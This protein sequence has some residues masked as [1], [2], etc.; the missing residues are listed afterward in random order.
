MSIPITYSMHDIIFH[1]IFGHDYDA[2]LELV[3]ASSARLN[4]ICQCKY[5]QA[6]MQA[7]TQARASAQPVPINVLKAMFFLFLNVDMVLKDYICNTSSKDCF[8]AA[9]NT[10]RNAADL[11]KLHA[12]SMVATKQISPGKA[13]NFFLALNQ[14][15]VKQWLQDE[16]RGPMEFLQAVKDE[17][18]VS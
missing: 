6:T 18:L 8:A 3:T 10:K 13:R 14:K 16:R 7:V 1:V 2:I 11:D 17:Y 5:L 12:W 9:M 4:S 15:L